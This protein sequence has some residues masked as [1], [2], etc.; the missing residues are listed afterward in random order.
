MSL[1]F[2]CFLC[3]FRFS[4]SLSDEEDD[5]EELDDSSDEC[6]LLLLR[7]FFRFSSSLSES[8]DSEDDDVSSD[9]VSECFRFLRCSEKTVKAVSGV[10]LGQALLTNAL[11]TFV[12]LARHCSCKERVQQACP[13]PDTQTRSL[14]V[15]AARSSK[16]RFQRVT[17]PLRKGHGNP[18]PELGTAFREDPEVRRR[19]ADNGFALTSQR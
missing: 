5:D 11:L 7:F 17:T 10:K 13:C 14:Q 19:C 15:S 8:E 16:L 9:D 18:Q 2:L 12:R 1:C 3:F 4:S 6:F